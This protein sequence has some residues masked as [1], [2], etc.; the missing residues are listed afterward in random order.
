MQLVDQADDPPRRIDD[1]AKVFPGTL[2][3]TGHENGI[4]EA[5][6]DQIVLERALVLEIGAAL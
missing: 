5:A 6:V 3:A 1:V 2:L 4:L